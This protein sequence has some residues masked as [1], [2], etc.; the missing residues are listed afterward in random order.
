VPI[1]NLQLTLF[2]CFPIQFSMDSKMG[3]INKLLL[4]LM[5]LKNKGF[6]L[7]EVLVVIA[8]MS[9]LFLFVAP[10]LFSSKKDS[11][12]TALKAS[13]QTINIGLLRAYKDKD[14]QIKP[15]GVL[16]TSPIAHPMYTNKTE[17][18][19]AYLIERGYV[20]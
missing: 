11:Q 1:V 19:L 15:G 3:K 12:E 7:I 18:A 5:G 13:L 2:V 10:A 20:R 14:P 6:T 17:N 9:I 8:I 4:T 16:S